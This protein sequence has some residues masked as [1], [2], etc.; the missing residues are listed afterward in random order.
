[1]KV[2]TFFYSEGGQTLELVAQID[3]GVYSPGNIQNLSGYGS[4][5]PVLVDLTV[6]RSLDWMT[7]RDSLQS[8]HFSDS[9]FNH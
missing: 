1:M 2:K 8:Q 5:Q 7:S 9:V 6:S 4:K 3:W